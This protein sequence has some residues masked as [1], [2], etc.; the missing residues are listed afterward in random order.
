MCML[1][2]MT[3]AARTQSIHQLGVHSVKKLS[4]EFVFQYDGLIKQSRPGFKKTF[5]HMKAYPPDRRLC[6]CTVIKEYLKRSSLFRGTK[7]KLLL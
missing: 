6:I 3:G 1:I 4:S 5:L 2:A 7:C